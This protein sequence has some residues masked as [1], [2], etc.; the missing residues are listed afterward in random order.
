MSL[1]NWTSTHIINTDTDS[2]GQPKW[3]LLTDPV[4]SD[5][6]AQIKRLNNFKVTETDPVT[7]ATRNCLTATR[8]AYSLPVKEV[9]QFS[10]SNISTAGEYILK[11]YVGLSQDSM[12][13]YYSNDLAYKGR[14]FVYSF[15]LSAAQI[16]AGAASLA[17]LIAEHINTNYNRFEDYKFFTAV[18]NG[19]NVELH[20]NDEF[21]IFKSAELTYVDPT[22]PLMSETEVDVTFSKVTVGKT[23]F[24][25]YFWLMTNFALPTY[26]KYRL[27]A[28]N[29]EELPVPGANYDQYTLTYVQFR[30]ELGSGNAVGARRQETVTTHVFYVQNSGAAATSGTPAPASAGVSK[31]FEDFLT[32]AGLT[33]TPVNVY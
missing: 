24:G 16:S 8:K 17:T 28:D 7:G 33:V 21:Q 14:G 12:N 3:E 29:R 4:T 18:A 15:T 11:I 30:P 10:T 20:A 19:T 13:S 2:S 6:I 32:S 9:A 1:F 23:G 31:S 27:A 5:D 25:T 26:D 22:T